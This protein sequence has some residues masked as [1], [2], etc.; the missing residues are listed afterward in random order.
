LGWWK[1]F[2]KLERSFFFLFFF[3]KNQKKDGKNS[4]F[5]LDSFLS[6]VS[7]FSPKDRRDERH[8]RDLPQLLLPP[9][10]RDSQQQQQQLELQ[11]QLRRRSGLDVKDAD[12]P[13]PP[14]LHHLGPPVLLFFSVFFSASP[15]A[16]DTA[17]PGSVRHRRS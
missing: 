10:E 14:S 3:C 1:W 8:R 2:R 17:A 13:K 11:Q 15:A 7:A 16:R 5:T 6:R 9:G 4:T 12:A